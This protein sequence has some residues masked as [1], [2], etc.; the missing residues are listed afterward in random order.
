MTPTYPKGDLRRLAAVL[1]AIDALAPA[2][3]LVKLAAATGL[4]KQTVTD[5]IGQ[6][7]EQAGVNIDKEGPV[8]R[9]LDWGPLIKKAGAHKALTG[10]LHGPIMPTVD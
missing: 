7:R 1:G 4:S 10:T 3:T 6:A 8:Y 5:L 9:L 2:A